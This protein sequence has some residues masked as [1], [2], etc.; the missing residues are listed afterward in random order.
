MDKSANNV[1]Y[2]PLPTDGSQIRLATILPGQ[3]HKKVKCTVSK[4][5][6]TKDSDG[7][8]EYEALSYVWG[9]ATVTSSITL[10]GKPF[11]VTTNL[12]NALRALRFP[13]KKRVVWIDAIC[14][15]QTSIPERNQEVRR[16][17][18]I[19]SRAKNVIVWLGLIDE[20][21]NIHHIDDGRVSNKLRGLLDTLA[22]LKP[23]DA[24]AAAVV[25]D[26]TGDPFYALQLL[27]NFFS[28]PWFNRIWVL[29]EIALA[30]MATIVYGD[31]SISWDRFEQA[32]DAMRRLQLGRYTHLWRLSGAT[33][34]DSIWRCR[35][36]TRSYETEGKS[37]PL[38][39]ELADYLWQTRFYERTEPRDRLFGILGLVKSDMRGEKLLEIDYMKPI[40]DVF[41]D[42]SIFMI[43]NGMLPQ[44]L[45]SIAKSMD[46]LP[47]WASL[48]SSELQGEAASRL[49][50]GLTMYM[51]I[52]A[53]KGVEPIPNPPRISDNLRR[54]TVKGIIV[55]YGIGHVGKRFETV[56]TKTID[57]RALLIRKRFV[58]WEEE[59]E[60]ERCAHKIFETQSER[61]EAWKRALLHE[62]PGD[63]TELGQHYDLLKNFKNELPLPM[64]H[65]ILMSVVA[66]IDT[67]LGK[68]SDC[69][70]PFVTTSGLMGSTGTNCDL[71]FGDQIGVLVGSGV[72]YMLR[73]VDPSCELFQFVGCCWVPELVD[74]D[75]IEGEKK[76]LWEVRDITLI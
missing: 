21:D 73:A 2:E 6:F 33:R 55:D 50:R 4:F 12:E 39:L 25:L 43:K 72:P 47:S 8:L 62:L 49:S 75:L 30:K 3:K 10:N 65:A 46:G 70:R 32:L 74:L 31:M 18:E 56:P 48:W 34:A 76:G 42:L 68:N 69:R 59:M 71:C 27:H 20:P 51:Q 58:E 5:P 41:R 53:F 14:I 28:R 17:G 38:H 11:Q 22:D 7:G 37:S 45:C 60:R 29:Q 1:N 57:E 13:K 19:Y 64:D 26:R 44:V 66:D 15:N 63:E 52:H 24:E 61:R 35:M 16:M 36:R 9:E 67:T 54:I 40:T 23:E